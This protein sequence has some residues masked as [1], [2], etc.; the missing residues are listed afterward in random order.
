MASAS[1]WSPTLRRPWLPARP[2]E[3]GIEIIALQVVLDGVSSP[4][5]ASGATGADVAAALRAGRPG[6]HLP[7]VAGGVFATCYREA[8]ERGASAAVS[9]HLSGGDLGH[10]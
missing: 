2:D 9:V 5:G 8:A 7:T 1:Q 6:D 3:A 4:E 10:L